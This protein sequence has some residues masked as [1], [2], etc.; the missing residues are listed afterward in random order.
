MSNSSFRTPVAERPTDSQRA[1]RSAN[2]SLAV[3]VID[4]AAVVRAGVESLAGPCDDIVSVHHAPDPTTALWRIEKVR[5]DVVLAGQ[6]ALDVPTLERL[7]KACQ[8]EGRPRLLVFS[9][10]PGRAAAEARRAFELGAA[11]FVCAAASAQELLEAIRRV[12]RGQRYLDPSVG[13]RL[14]DN[15]R[16]DPFT[17]L[18]AREREIAKLLALG[19]TNQQ[20]A[21]RLYLSVRTVETHRAR[22][23][24]K[25]RLGTRAEL[26][27]CALDHGLI[28]PSPER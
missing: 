7:G 5:P 20:V 1:S 3:L 16:Q 14:A 10:T 2:G 17:E 13:A 6:G 27:R 11:G 8:G 24:A 4:S 25:L 28:G 18:T 26:V 23:L 12:G 19:H 9:T 21:S 22:A 15:G